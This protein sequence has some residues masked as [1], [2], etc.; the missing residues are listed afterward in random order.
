M[1]RSAAARC[2]LL[3]ACLS[4]GWMHC[5]RCGLQGGQIKATMFK[6]V[7]ERLFSVF[8]ENKVYM[9]SKGTLKVPFEFG[10]VPV[11]WVCDS[12]L[13]LTWQPANKKWSK[14]PND[15][16]LTLNSDCEVTLC[17]DDAEIEHQ[18]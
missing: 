2:P 16:E 6:E 18:R 17:E 9:I 15:Y 5:V 14:L 12:L 13:P 3:L 10:H 11:S 1:Q 8:E 7:A 4:C